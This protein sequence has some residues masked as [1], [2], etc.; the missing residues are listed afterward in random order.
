MDWQSGWHINFLALGINLAGRDEG[1]VRRF[2]IEARGT[3]RE[4]PI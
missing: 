3:D 1:N 2:E 4:T